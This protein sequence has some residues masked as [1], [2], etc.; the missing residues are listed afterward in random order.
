MRTAMMILGCLFVIGAG[1]DCLEVSAV[2]GGCL[3]WLYFFGK[4]YVKRYG[5]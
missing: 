5:K 1:S 4:Q 2:C 3:I